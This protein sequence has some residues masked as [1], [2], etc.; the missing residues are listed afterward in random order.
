MR[1]SARARSRL[2]KPSGTLL[3]SA[4]DG[5]HGA[6]LWKWTAQGRGGHGWQP[7]PDDD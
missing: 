4:D 7:T 1:P 3:F 2:A 5:K 6:E